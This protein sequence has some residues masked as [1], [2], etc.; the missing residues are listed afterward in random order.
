MSRSIPGR[1]LLSGNL[2]LQRPL[3][4][5]SVEVVQL[6]RNELMHGWPKAES[7][8]NELADNLVE[9]ASAAEDPVRAMAE[10]VPDFVIDAVSHQKSAPSRRSERGR[11]RCRNA[12]A[13]VTWDTRLGTLSLN[14]PKVREGRVVPKLPLRLRS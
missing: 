13:T 8:P 9:T 2:G 4:A 3:A 12:T 7:S 11:K 5:G 14:V 1:P 6:P 10:M